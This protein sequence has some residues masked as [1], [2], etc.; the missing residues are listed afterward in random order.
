MK[1]QSSFAFAEDCPPSGLHGRSNLS[2][3]RLSRG[4]R[5]IPILCVLVAIPSAAIAAE[6]VDLNQGWEFRQNAGDTRSTWQAAVVPGDVHLDLLRNKLIPDPFYRDNETAIQ[7][8]EKSSWTYRTTLQA[9]AEMLHHAHLDLVFEGLDT[10]A[11]VFL[12]GKEVL[13][14][15]NMFRKWR[16]DVKT[17]LHAGAN[18]LRIEFPS[19]GPVATALAA[20]N[21]EQNDVHVPEKDYLRKAAYE[22]GWDWGPRFVTSGV[23]KPLYIEAWDEARVDDLYIAQPDVS[24]SVAHLNATTH[25]ISSADAMAEVTLHYKADPNGESLEIA[26]KVALHKGDNEIAIP[27]EIQHPKLWFP[28]GYGDPSRYTFSITVKEGARTEDQRTVH[29]G[30][31]SIVLDR[32]PD[33]WG[34]SFGFIVN[35]IPIFAKGADVIPFDSFPN[36]VTEEQ[37]ARI[38]HS[39]KDANMNMIRLWGGGYY[40]SDKFYDMCDELGLMVWHDLMFASAWYPGNEDFKQNVRT[41]VEEQVKR[42]RNH[43]SITIWAGNNED[44]SVL[45]AFLGGQSAENRLQI[46]KDYLTVFSGIFPSIIQREDPDVP[47]WPSSPSADYEKTSDSFQSGDAHDWSIWHGREPFTNYDNHFYR[48]FSEY[49][50]QSFPELKTVESFTTP[51]DRANIFTPVMLAHQKNNE[52]NDIIH[53][54]LLRDYPEPKDF[55]SFLYVSQVLQAEGVKEGAEHTRRNRPRIMGSLFWQL[56]DCWPV[57]SWSSI[58]YY[59]RWKALQYY[60]RRFYSPVLVSPTLS[61]GKVLVYGVSD[62]QQELNATLRLRVMDMKGIVVQESKQKISLPPLSAA[63][64]L[65]VPLQSIVEKHSNLS[66]LFVAVDLTEGGSVLTSNVMYLEP[67]EQVHLQ[68]AV[69]HTDLK[70]AEGGYQLSLTSDVL[71]RDVYITTGAQD[72]DISDNFFNLLPGEPVTITVTSKADL[73]QLKTQLKV[74]SLVEAFSKQPTQ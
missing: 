29:T 6:R 1:N 71:A 15:D 31:R 52:G 14:A 69:I 57:A 8:I 11:H 3:G 28:A 46:W 47:Y 54:Y 16:V 55:A 17:D 67:T 50:F 4:L 62:R 12:N 37:Y 56:N 64:Y 35:G 61:D 9:N 18:E 25:V 74:T 66:D 49:G 45:Y 24:A 60:A 53:Q 72:A 48:F 42:L 7:W 44:E 63:P 70:P 27:V 36:R 68:P 21:P 2:G 26:R 58:D 34:R 39:A 59:G 38:L 20:A 10:T 40:E 19:P 33:Q 41:E 51:E 32:H 73:E 43:P 30:L 22:Y 5:I 13:A 23:W 65:T